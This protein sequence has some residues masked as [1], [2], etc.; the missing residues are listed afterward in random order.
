MSNDGEDTTIEQDALR[1]VTAIPDGEQQTSIYAHIEGFRWKLAH[2][3]T[4]AWKL[5]Q[6]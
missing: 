3:V 1:T 6:D 5:L 4:H 2:H